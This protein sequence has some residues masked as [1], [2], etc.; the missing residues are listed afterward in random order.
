MGIGDEVICVEAKDT[1]LV[2]GEKYVVSRLPANRGVMLV[3][4]GIAYFSKSR[5]RTL[6]EFR[7][8]KI[9]KIL[10]EENYN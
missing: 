5:F 4:K 9:N 8:E 10:D 2:Y 1:V 6:D 7:E 3:N